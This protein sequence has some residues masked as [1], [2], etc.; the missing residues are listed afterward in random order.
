MSE[1][2]KP[3]PQTPSEKGARANIFEPSEDLL[4]RLKTAV[5]KQGVKYYTPYTLAQELNIRISVARKLL[6]EAEKRGIVKLYSGGRRAPVYI[7]AQ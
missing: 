2:K 4:K 6:R 1:K 3:A 7:P 5:S